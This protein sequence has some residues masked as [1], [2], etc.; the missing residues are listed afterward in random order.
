MAA[1]SSRLMLSGFCVIR[2]G[3]YKRAAVPNVKLLKNAIEVR[4]DCAF[5]YAQVAGD[6]F[7]CET[8]A[9]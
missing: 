2:Q 7:V 5:K 1:L 3:D 6:F 8:A 4:F 9:H